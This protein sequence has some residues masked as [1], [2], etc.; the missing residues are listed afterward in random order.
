MRDCVGDE[1]KIEG[2]ECY[3]SDLGKLFYTDKYVSCFGIGDKYY[4]NVFDGKG[5]DERYASDVA[6]LRGLA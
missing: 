1:M 5:A 6:F 3:F 4:F 2:I